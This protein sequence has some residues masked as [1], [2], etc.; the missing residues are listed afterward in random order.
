MCISI[1]ISHLSISYLALTSL[2]SQWV[3]VGFGL[4]SP[5]RDVMQ[6]IL[7]EI[8]CYRKTLKYYLLFRIKF[9]FVIPNNIKYNG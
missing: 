5:Q 3:S 6:C 2:Y 7:G 9:R 8:R 1:L 4:S